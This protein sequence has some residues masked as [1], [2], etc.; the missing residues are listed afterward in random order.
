[1]EK[2]GL[3]LNGRMCVCSEYTA[4]LALQ[5]ILESVNIIALFCFVNSF[6]SRLY[7]AGVSYIA[8]VEMGRRPL[9]VN[10][11]EFARDGRGSVPTY[12]QRDRNLRNIS[13][14]IVRNL[15]EIRTG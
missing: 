5:Q 9:V 10:K 7:F 15:I 11:Y 13:V 1:M 4:V 8:P 12:L 2:I 6:S 3:K 14:R